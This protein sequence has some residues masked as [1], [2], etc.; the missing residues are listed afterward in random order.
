MYWTGGTLLTV[1]YL[2]HRRSKDVDVFSESLPDDLTVAA[3]MRDIARAAGATTPRHVR[4][5]NR[6]QYFL[7]VSRGE[8]LKLEI[9]YFPFPALGKRPIV[10]AYG[11][12]ID[13]LRDLAAN[14]AHAAFERAEPRDALDLY[15]ILRKQRWTLARVVRDVEQKFGI[16]L[17]TV[18][19]VARLQ[20]AAAGLLDLRP[21][22]VGKLP[23]PKTISD[24]FQAHANRALRK[25][26]GHR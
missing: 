6:W 12:R 26:L 22:A 8:E 21:L 1:H 3:A 24:F 13:S 14:K 2:H 20:E 18:H 10:P 23:S 15:A 4:F 5:P 17:D 9:V 7:D 11:L 16:T 25:T 19:L